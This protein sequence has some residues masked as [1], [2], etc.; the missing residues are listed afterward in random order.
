[1]RVRAALARYKSELADA[2]SQVTSSARD[3]EVLPSS[4]HLP[5]DVFSE[6]VSEVYC[7]PIGCEGDTG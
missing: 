2:K 3:V 6:G 4:A 7:N 1:M 5:C